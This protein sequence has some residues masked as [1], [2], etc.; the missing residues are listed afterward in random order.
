VNRVIAVANCICRQQQ[1]LLGQGCDKPLE[2]CLVFGS[3]AE[4]YIETGR[5][6][7][8]TQ[9]DAMGILKTAEHAGLVLQPANDQNPM[10]IC[11]CCGCCCGILANL[12]KHPEPASLVSSSYRA[13]LD[14]DTCAAC[15]ECIERC[16]MDALKL[17]GGTMWLNQARCIGCGLCVTI[18]PTGSLTLE[19]KPEGELT[20][21]PRN[22]TQSFI[23]NA[24]ALGKF[25]Y[26]DLLLTGLRS[27]LDRLRAPR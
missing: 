24:R 21:V 22:I 17:E 12:K 5:G 9:D 11:A 2:T 27:M 1:R 18:C 26:R 14:Q 7:E 13:V 19:R 10:N 16:Q 25:G 23:R 15:G 4:H 6:R 20:P 3:A 8:I